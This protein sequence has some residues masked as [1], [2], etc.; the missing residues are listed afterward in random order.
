M[1]GTFYYLAK[2]D[3]SGKSLGGPILIGKIAG[4]SF[5]AG[6]TQF[7]QMM[8]FLSL[9]LFIFNLLPIPVLD[10]GHLV[11]FAIEAIRRKPLN[12]KVIEVW[13]T[14]GFFILM[15]LIVFVFFNDISR[16]GFLKIF[17]LWSY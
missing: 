7:L 11:L 3:I 9:N 16:L 5:R 6:G 17:G 13:T 10:G 2:G 8:S 12:I 14:T 4:D 1:L 15:G